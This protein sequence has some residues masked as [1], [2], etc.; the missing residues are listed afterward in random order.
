MEAIRVALA[1]RRCLW[2]A[3]CQHRS[4]RPR[5]PEAGWPM[6]DPM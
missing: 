6:S 3:F 5:R 1:L 2:N 4:V